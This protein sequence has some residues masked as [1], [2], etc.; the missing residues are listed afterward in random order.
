MAESKSAKI[1]YF[2]HGTTTD[3]EKGI[4]TGWAPGRLSKLGEEQCLQLRRLIKRRKF[5]IVFSSDLKR[6]VDSAKLVFGN[7]VPIIKDRRLRECNYG[8]LTRANSGDVD[9]LMLKCINKSFPKGESYKGVEKRMRDFLKDLVSKH[10]GKHIAIMS[11][12]APQLALDVILKGKSWK[13]AMKEDWRH[14]KK[15]KPGWVYSL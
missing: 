14:L 1:T 4:A 3:N 10:S 9:K 6:A 11:H 12:R 5:D 8:G 2:V 15:W 7:K 13:T